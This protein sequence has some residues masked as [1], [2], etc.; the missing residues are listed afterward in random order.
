MLVYNVY[1]GD[2]YYKNIDIIISILRVYMYNRLYLIG[3][4][5]LIIYILYIRNNKRI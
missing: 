3:G 5:L 4:L 1:N 2:V